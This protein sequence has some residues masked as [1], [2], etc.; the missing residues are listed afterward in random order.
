MVYLNHQPIGGEL[1]FLFKLVD[2]ILE[3]SQHG[4]LIILFVDMLMDCINLEQTSL[5]FRV[6]SCCIASVAIA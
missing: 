4:N 3:C 2:C 5:G 1:W 6:S